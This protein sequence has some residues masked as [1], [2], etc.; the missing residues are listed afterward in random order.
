MVDRPAGVAWTHARSTTSVSF[1]TK[2]PHRLSDRPGCDRKTSKLSK[3]DTL[4]VRFRTAAGGTI[5]FH[6]RRNVRYINH[7]IPF[8]LAHAVCYGP[9]RS[10]RRN[11]PLL[12]H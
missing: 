8:G 11:G 4:R 10:A 5:V 7:A 1:S 6:L 3:G 12:S 2:C 9:Q